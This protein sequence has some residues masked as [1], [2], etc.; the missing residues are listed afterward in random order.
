MR[1]HR[2]HV[3]LLHVQSNQISMLNVSFCRAEAVEASERAR[4]VAE[5]HQ[6]RRE[7]AVNK[8]RGQAQWQGPPLPT[9]QPQKQTPQGALIC[10]QYSAGYWLVNIYMHLATN[11]HYIVLCHSD[12]IMYI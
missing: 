6:R 12:C 4:V 5:Y 1:L 3:K 9:P 11:V 7:A 10:I 8:A 2:T